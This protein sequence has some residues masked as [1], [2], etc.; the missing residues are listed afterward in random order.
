MA[1]VWKQPW[2]H[3]LNKRTQMTDAMLQQTHRSKVAQ[4]L[5]HIFSIYCCQVQCSQIHIGLC[6]TVLECRIQ[7]SICII[8]FTEITVLKDVFSTWV[9]AFFF[10]SCNKEICIILNFN[11]QVWINCSV[12]LWQKHHIA[13]NTKLSLWYKMFLCSGIKDRMQE[14]Q[15]KYREAHK[16]FSQRSTVGAITGAVWLWVPSQPHWG[17]VHTIFFLSGNP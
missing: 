5:L 13:T 10:G 9:Y 3:Y 7:T 12:A 2:S 8:P 16:H 14:L 17:C 11:M 1:L 15:V 4:I 6:Y